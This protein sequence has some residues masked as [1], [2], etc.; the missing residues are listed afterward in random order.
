[1]NP[2][3]AKLKKIGIDQ[4]SVGMFVVNLGRSWLS[5]PFLRNQLK[6]TSDK[7]IEKMRKYG[8]REVYIDPE[9]GLNTREPAPEP[10]VPAKPSGGNGQEAHNP[11]A[12]L[13]ENIHHE[14][15]ILSPLPRPKAEEGPEGHEA[16]S[17][18]VP[19]KSESADFW[20]KN[21]EKL[22]GN[23]LSLHAPSAGPVVNPVPFDQEIK[24]ARKVQEEAQVVIRQSMH[25]VRM[26]RSI[27]SERV[28]RVVH[29]MV[30]SIL[31]NNDALVSLTRLK[32]YD[33][34]TFIHS[35]D[36]CILCLSM[37]RHLS[38]PREEMMEFGIGALLHDLGKMKISPHI[39]KKPGRLT[40]DEWI[41]M[42]KHP[43]YSLEMMAQGKD[44][45]E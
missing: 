26:G 13:I 29:N 20:E 28:K 42:R 34:Y 44:I 16:F 15:E 24:I 2:D 37:A 41:E 5:H 36:V 39:L 6:I 31:R 43:V 10:K 8:I 17:A 30:D 9:R 27:E 32:T 19:E 23:L 38:L 33:E 7:Q 25:E 1:M 22:Q 12:T 4:L 11:E 35:L 3:Q 40:P 14:E 45:P 21:I 18:E